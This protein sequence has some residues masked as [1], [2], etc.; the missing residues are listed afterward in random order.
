MFSRTYSRKDRKKPKSS[1]GT[2]VGTRD[3]R[4]I[5]SPEG[6]NEDVL[7]KTEKAPETDEEIMIRL[8]LHET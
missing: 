2:L 4:N 8:D 6:Y 3:K 5:F 1:F 7:R